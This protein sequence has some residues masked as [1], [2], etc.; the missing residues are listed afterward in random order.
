M[1]KKINIATPKWVRAGRNF[2]FQGALSKNR[3][4]ATF[5]NDLFWGFCIPS[6][7]FFGSQL[8]TLYLIAQE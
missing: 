1:G 3:C 4:C 6:R 8:S 2:P 7:V 5:L